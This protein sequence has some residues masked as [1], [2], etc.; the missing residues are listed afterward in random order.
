MHLLG[1]IW[2]F[3]WT[4]HTQA[5]LIKKESRHSYI[6]LENLRKNKS[7]RK[8]VTLRS[9]LWLS[10]FPA[11]VLSADNLGKQFGPRSGPT[12]RRSWSGSNLFDTLTVFLKEFFEKVVFEKNH[13]TTKKHEKLCRRQRVYPIY[14]NSLQLREHFN[15][16]WPMDSSIQFNKTIMFFASIIKS[17]LKC[18]EIYAA[19]VKHR[20]HFQ[21]KKVDGCKG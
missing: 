1:C 21:G 9:W 14:H 6:S 7:N 19:D 12:K 17:S 10:S 11:I 13:Q 3:V 8:L 2:Y 5:K 20:Q 18:T 4:W 15:L 16:F